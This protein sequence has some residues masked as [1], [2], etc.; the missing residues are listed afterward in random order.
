MP[1]WKRNNDA[2][3]DRRTDT[4]A[5]AG[6][7]QRPYTTVL[8]H[9]VIEIGRK[10]LYEDGV[11]FCG[12]AIT[13]A[14]ADAGF[15]IRLDHDADPPPDAN[16]PDGD[17]EIV[18]W[19]WIDDHCIIEEYNHFAD[20]RLADGGIT[21]F[22]ALDWDLITALRDR[23]HNPQETAQNW[24]L[25]GIDDGYLLILANPEQLQA[26]GRSPEFPGFGVTDLTGAVEIGR[27]PAPR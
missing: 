20:I 5:A 7:A 24:Q 8:G 21:S 4:D 3:R 19:I 16:V 14:Y 10:E 9:A 23:Y 26:I 11:E 15:D 27:G 18:R 12:P 6:A 17:D 13:A 1:F 25:G 22:Q 2:G